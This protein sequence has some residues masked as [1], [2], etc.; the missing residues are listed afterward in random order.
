M[1]CDLRQVIYRKLFEQ[2]C[3]V[4]W[5]AEHLDHG[6]Q[7]DCPLWLFQESGN[8]SVVGDPTRRPLAARSLGEGL[9]IDAVDRSATFAQL[10]AGCR[11]LAPPT[12]NAFTLERMPEEGPNPQR[13]LLVW[14]W[15]L[16]RSD[17][18]W[19]AGLQLARSL[20]VEARLTAFLENRA[21]E[22]PGVAPE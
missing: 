20:A 3:P 21:D 4:E 13:A 16:S 11:E 17:W 6:E 1:V 10:Q 2:R 15:K 8:I 9:R 7:N 19:A 22:E 12:A 14:F 18:D 5:M